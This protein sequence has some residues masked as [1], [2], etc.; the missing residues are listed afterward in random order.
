MTRSRRTIAMGVTATGAGRPHLSHTGPRTSIG[1]MLG[2]A[3]A[4]RRKT[5]TDC[6][7]PLT[8]RDLLKGPVGVLGP[9]LFGQPFHLKAAKEVLNLEVGRCTTT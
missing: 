5:A 4:K 7:K 1:V 9:S 6:A 2:G 8:R 3:S